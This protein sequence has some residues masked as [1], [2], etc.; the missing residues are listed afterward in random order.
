MNVQDILN[1]DEARRNALFACYIK[2][3]AAIMQK[4]SIPLHNAIDSRYD[5]EIAEIL[6]QEDSINSGNVAAIL[7]WGFFIM[8][9]LE[10]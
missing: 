7:A 2:A 8:R 5:E 4:H 3:L 9:S 1:L 10:I 6:L